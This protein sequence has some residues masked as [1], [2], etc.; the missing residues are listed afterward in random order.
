M[1]ESFQSQHFRRLPGR[2]NDRSLPPKGFRSCPKLADRKQIPGSERRARGLALGGGWP[3]H[4]KEIPLATVTVF[5]ARPR[6]DAPPP[7]SG[8]AWAPAVVL[9]RAGPAHRSAPLRWVRR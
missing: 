1:R 8:T 2:S 4:L 7:S 3:D 5:D 9:D 6:Y